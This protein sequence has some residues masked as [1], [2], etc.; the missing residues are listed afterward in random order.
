MQHSK[1]LDSLVL[2]AAFL[3]IASISLAQSAE[4]SPQAPLNRLDG[5]VM[6]V[7]LTQ[8]ERARVAAVAV[9]HGFLMYR[10]GTEI[11]VSAP[12]ETVLLFFT[13]RNGSGSGLAWTDENGRFSIQGLKP[14]KYHLLAVHPEKGIRLVR[15]VDQ[16][17]T[18]DGVEIAL[19]APTFVE[20]TIRGVPGADLVPTEQITKGELIQTFLEPV[21]LDGWFQ[22]SHAGEST[23]IFVHLGF[24]IGEDGAFK[25][26]PLPFDGEWDLRIN[27]L[28]QARKFVAT[29]LKL[30]LNVKAGE[31]K[32]IDVDLA[33]G[34]ALAGQIVGPQGEPLADAAVSITSQDSDDRSK[35]QFGTLADA[36]GEYRIFAPSEGNYTLEAQRWAPRTGFG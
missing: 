7:D 2:V 26:G 25:A 1:R 27:K 24:K 29:L 9:Q 23:R 36:K 8:V 6:A 30:P 34:H 13:K 21:S 19:P 4:P 3:G 5:R 28:V 35:R 12:E 11:F 32:R 10:G 22:N 14:G 20:G 17:T 31:A 33:A 18:G 15:S 16:P